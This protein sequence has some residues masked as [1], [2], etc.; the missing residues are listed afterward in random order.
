M[1]F[2]FIGLDIAKDTFVASIFHKPKDTVLT[3]E[4]LS[5]DKHGYDELI[6]WIEHPHQSQCQV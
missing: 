1:N 5:N 2:Y 6:L 3:K 4:N